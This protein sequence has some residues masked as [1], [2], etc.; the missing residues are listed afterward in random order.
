MDQTRIINLL[1][2]KV[3]FLIYFGLG[4]INGAISAKSNQEFLLNKENIGKVIGPA[5]G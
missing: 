4:G 5:I 1:D 2:M 3:T